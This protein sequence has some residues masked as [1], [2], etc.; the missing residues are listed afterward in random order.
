MAKAVCRRII[1]AGARVRALVSPCGICGGQN[2]TGEDSSP[3]SSISPCQ[4]RRSSVCIVSG[5]VLDNRAIE[6][7]FPA[8]AI[9]FRL[10]SVSRPAL[11]PTQPPVQW[12]SGVLFPGVTR[13]WGVTL[14][15]P[16]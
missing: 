4:Y 15:T 14:T 12:V 5:Y 1:T 6:V 10:T 9:V 2:G 8:V 16:F 11:G 13:G 7:R 3:S